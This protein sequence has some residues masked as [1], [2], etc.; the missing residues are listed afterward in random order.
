LEGTLNVACFWLE[1][2]GT[3]RV[4]MRRYTRE[5][6]ACPAS[7]S[8]YHQAV[9]L[10]GDVTVIWSDVVPDV[11]RCFN[12]RDGRYGVADYQWPPHDDPRWPR[13]CKCGRPFS[14]DDPWQEWS[15]RLYQRADTGRLLTLREAP[16]GAMWDA[17]WMPWKGPDGRSLMVKCPGGHEWSV[18]SRASNCTMR[19]DNEHRCWVRH[20]EPPVITVDKNGLTCQAGAGSILTG[21][22]HGFLRN[23]Q[24]T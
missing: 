5:K 10:T 23:G 17:W 8:G 13:I 14:P 4:G 19:D 2:T 7:D 22:Y 20:G 18:D 15:E 9:N 12:D 6:D 3:V 24:F 21:N 11:G 1:E 16:D